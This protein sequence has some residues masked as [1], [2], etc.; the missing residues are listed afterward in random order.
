MLDNTPKSQQ[1]LLNIKIAI[2]VYEALIAYRITSWS[3]DSVDIGQSIINLFRGYLRLTEHLRKFGKKKGG[4]AKKDK[5]KDKDGNDTIKKG[6]RPAT[7]KL[8]NTIMDF[9]TISKCIVLL[10]K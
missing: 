10:Y 1:K 5:D 4:K 2:S 9:D 7:I 3:L 6:G 8:P